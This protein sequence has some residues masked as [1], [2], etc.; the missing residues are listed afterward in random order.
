MKR[1]GIAI[2]ISAFVFFLCIQTNV[3]AESDYGQESIYDALPDEVQSQFDEE[4]ITSGTAITEMSPESVFS[5]LLSIAAEKIKEPFTLF[6]SLLGVILL[7]AMVELLQDSSGS[8]SVSEVFRIVGVLAGTGIMCG[9]I[10]SAMEA[11]KAAIDNYSTFLLTYIPAFA[12]ILAVNGQ[13]ATAATYNVLIVSVSEFFAQSASAALIPAISCILG[14]SAAGAINPELNIQNLAEIAKKAIN[15][16]LG[17]LM[18]AFAG[19]LSVQSFIT[20][21]TDT[22]A[23]KTAKFTVSSTVPIVGGAVSE[24]LGT[25]KSC[26]SLLKSSVGSFGIVA[27]LAI[28]IPT[29]IMTFCFRFAFSAAS[30]ASEMFGTKKLTSLLKCGESIMSIMNAV[31]I[32]LA[33]LVVVS[34]AL[35]LSLGGGGN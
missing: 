33:V 17:I 12:G 21:A 15:W 2:F 3:S 16:T 9:F 34:T 14:I 7:C 24:A 35:M 30:A 8:S 31:L 26:V 4:D 6:I 25:V 22:V 10:G 13:A 29:L 11:V 5:S 27:A 18:T 19:L 23:L 28:I 32:C 20:S 1:K